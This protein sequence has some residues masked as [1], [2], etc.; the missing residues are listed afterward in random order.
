MKKVSHLL[1]R[2]LP[3]GLLFA[4]TA[5][6]ATDLKRVA[7]RVARRFAGSILPVSGRAILVVE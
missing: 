5:R 1:L 4:V 7:A 3:L 6:D 2:T